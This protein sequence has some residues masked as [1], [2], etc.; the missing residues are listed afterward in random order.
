MA[1]SGVNGRDAPVWAQH[2]F[3]LEGVIYSFIQQ[4]EVVG[5]FKLDLMRS[6]NKN[7]T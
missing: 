7:V 4:E 6:I 1:C 3:S 2:R 5:I